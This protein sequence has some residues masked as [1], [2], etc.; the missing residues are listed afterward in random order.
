[1]ELVRYANEKMNRCAQIKSGIKS[2]G[3]M[4]TKERKIVNMSN[5]PLVTLL[6]LKE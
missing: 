3:T 2:E 5:S 6:K 4:K 1:M